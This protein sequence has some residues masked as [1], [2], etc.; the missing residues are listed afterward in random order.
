MKLIIA[1][2]LLFFTFKCFSQKVY[3]YD[4]WKSKELALATNFENISYMNSTEKE[5]LFYTNLVRINP[6]LFCETYL[7]EYIDQHGYISTNS[8]ISSLISTLNKSKSKNP[9]FCDSN[10]YEMAKYHTVF[11]GIKGL[12][13]H[14]GFNERV[15]RFL[16]GKFA[17]EG[18]NCNYGEEKSLD[19]FMSLLIDEGV[20]SLGHRYNILNT[21]FTAV[22][23]SIQ[24]HKKYG[25]NCVMDF[26]Y[27]VENKK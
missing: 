4:K 1:F 5:I 11:M 20:P 18:E 16:K 8:Y 15:K 2:I 6:K 9:L 23:I 22:G 19:I 13:G 14:N 12:E 10:L 21:V 26:G 7:Q 24:P 3:P 25:V 17:M 27:L